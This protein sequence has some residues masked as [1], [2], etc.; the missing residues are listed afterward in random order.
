MSNKVDTLINR[1][2]NVPQKS[3]EWLKLRHS[4]LTSSEIA[5][6]LECNNHE[7]SLELLKRK[8]SP[9]STEDLS[10]SVSISWGEK[11]EPIAKKI[12]EQITSESIN[13]VG[14]VIHEKFP[15]LGTSPDGIVN[16]GRL[17]EIKCPFHRKIIAGKI[18][19]YYWIQVQ[20]QMEICGFDECYFFQCQFE[21]KSL[22]FTS[23]PKD[24]MI[25]TGNHLDGTV[26]VLKDYTLEV[27]KRDQKWFTDN[28]PLLMDF[29]YK[30]QYY[31][32][33]G[34][35]KLVAD[36]G[37][38]QLYYN[39]ENNLLEVLSR[40]PKINTNI[41]NLSFDKKMTDIKTSHTKTSHTK[42]SHT[43]TKE[44]NIDKNV[45]S[46]IHNSFESTP[47]IQNTLSPLVLPAKIPEML[48]RED[49]IALPPK[50]TEI[51]SSI[52]FASKSP[53]IFFSLEHKYN[54]DEW[55]SASAI[56]NYLMQDPLLD[57]LNLYGKGVKKKITGNL[58]LDSS[59]SNYEDDLKN[60]SPFYQHLQ[61]KGVAF[62]DAVIS[63]LYKIHPDKIITIAN[64][65]QGRQ[66]DKVKET[67]DAMKS[68]KEIIYQAVLHNKRNKTYGIADLLIRSDFI[69]VL[70]ESEVLDKKTAVHGCAFNTKWHYVVVDI[71]HST[72]NFRADGVHLL[73]IGSTVAYKGQILI[74]NEAV[75]EEQ[76]YTPNISYILGRKW[77]Y[78]RKGEKYAGKGWF[79]CLGQINYRTVDR[80]I[81]QKTYDAIEWVKKVRSEGNNWSIIPPSVPELY[82]NMNNDNDAPWHSTKK[83][84]AEQL[85]EITSIWHCGVQHRNNAISKGIKSWR[86]EKCTSKI[87]GHK[88]PK[89]SPVL[90]AIL[91]INR[92]HDKIRPK[93]IK[94]RLPKTKVDIFLDFETVNDLI[95]DISK[96][97]TETCSSS[98]LY[99]IGIGWIV[100]GSSNWNYR[101]LTTDIINAENE[102]E[103]FLSM[104]DTLLEIAE[105][106]DAFE[107]MTIYHWSNAEIT[108]YNSTFAKYSSDMTEY[109]NLLSL[110]W[111]DLCNFFKA[112]CIVVKGAFDFSLK[113]IASMMF[114]HGFI[115]TCWTED[116]ILDGLNAMVKAMECSENAK[117]NNISMKE[118]PVVKK[119]IEYNEVDCKVMME[120][121]QYLKTHMCI[122]SVGT[123][124]TIRQTQI[125]Y[126]ESKRRKTN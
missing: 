39:L 126:R 119:I 116:G 42:T 25:Y 101:C 18:P 115:K 59:I 11:Y 20:A 81:V 52:N 46:E 32:I 36:M 97:K 8:C 67:N 63:Y 109:N 110:H 98:Y 95:S 91:N 10:S 70:F 106:N 55:V 41:T 92:S 88:G 26:W 104:H 68:G 72:L 5:S 19:Y 40:S 35:G 108:I 94:S 56:H 30:I 34:L 90:D 58:L 23:S 61:I 125:D 29:W 80:D 112:E 117:Q 13:N 37:N 79:D 75:G 62:E 53:P 43:K 121:L 118:L 84:L 2:I 6:A 45:S 7:S 69:N 99:M 3:V 28:F 74:Y 64:S 86:D 17:L 122:D 16:N 82:P 4:I 77:N 22:N 87:L 44:I 123:K 124:R 12:F 48:I 15:W 76:K 33:H 100:D 21:E 103:L 113:S 83:V 38:K 24:G 78:T 27:I 54:L 73:N 49:N 9:L 114:N 50:N 107:D 1:A 57:W 96:D 65:Y 111:F 14:L 93:Y 51:T 31:R 66:I 60:A 120:I 47:I 89:I 85:G 102:K 105:S 71:K